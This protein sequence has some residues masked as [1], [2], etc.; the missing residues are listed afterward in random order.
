VNLRCR[1]I[2]VVIASLAALLPMH[3]S[4]YLAQAPELSAVLDMAAQY[5]ARYE[6]RELGNLLVAES[7]LQTVITY[8]GVQH[9]TRL[10]TDGDFLILAIGQ[11]RVGLRIVNRVN[12]NPVQKKQTSF[13]EA[14]GNPS[15]GVTERIAAVQ[16]ESTRYNIGAINRTINV[17]TFALK[18]A[19]KTEAARFSFSKKG[20]KEVSG[21]KTWQIEFQERRGPTLTHGVHGESLLSSGTLWIEPSTGRILKTEMH[22]ENPFA[23][24]EAKA[25]ITTTYKE[26]NVLK[27]LVPATMEERYTAEVTTV[28]CVANYSKYRS[29]N[30]DVK[31]VIDSPP[32]P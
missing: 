17:P 31:S 4:V 28:S 20:E 12:G 25:T 8:G 32:R 19:R 26:N 3:S 1:P 7:Y 18:V 24:Q 21:K 22:V 10:Q 11:D 2:V 16:K 14:L 5:V 27:I 30:V 6:D 15:L 23:D 9:T 29:F 13:E